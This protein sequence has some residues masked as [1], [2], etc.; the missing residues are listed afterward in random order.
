VPDRP[1]LFKKYSSLKYRHLFRKWGTAFDFFYK[2]AAE[3][4]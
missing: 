4:F 1:K 2:E 3:I